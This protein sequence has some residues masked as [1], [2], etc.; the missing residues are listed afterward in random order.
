MPI[1]IMLTFKLIC[2]VDF[3]LAIICWHI[4]VAKKTYIP[5]S[6]NLLLVIICWHVIVAKK[7]YILLSWNFLLAMLYHVLE[8][9]K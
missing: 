6:W 8:S 3:L 1:N 9:W 7:T 4:I 2:I 5:L